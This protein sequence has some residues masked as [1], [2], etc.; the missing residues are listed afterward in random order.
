MS[1][2]NWWHYKL[3]FL[4]HRHKH[5]SISV[6]ISLLILSCLGFQWLMLQDSSV[7]L[8]YVS[9]IKLRMHVKPNEWKLEFRL[10]GRLCLRPQTTYP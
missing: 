5:S 3:I 4:H 1:Y 9:P 7:S 10:L 2:I 8:L 6:V